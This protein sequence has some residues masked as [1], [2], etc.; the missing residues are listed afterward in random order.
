MDEIF[1]EHMNGKTEYTSACFLHPTSIHIG[2]QE[3]LG[4]IWAK[5]FKI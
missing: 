3:S 1:R 5:Y 2:I 4:N